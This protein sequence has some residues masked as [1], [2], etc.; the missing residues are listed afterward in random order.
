[1]STPPTLLIGYGTLYLLLTMSRLQQ[2]RSKFQH[3]KENGSDINKCAKSDRQYN[4]EESNKVEVYHV[5]MTILCRVCQQ[6]R[7]Y[8][9]SHDGQQVITWPQHNNMCDVSNVTRKQM[10]STEHRGHTDH[11]NALPHWLPVHSKLW[12]WPIHTQKKSKSTVSW[13]KSSSGNNERRIDT[14]GCINFPAPPLTWSVI[15]T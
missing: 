9:C 11:I 6:W 10:P 8:Y 13:L 2:F 12:L 7:V 4:H 3:H 5:T 14:T 15:N 1:M